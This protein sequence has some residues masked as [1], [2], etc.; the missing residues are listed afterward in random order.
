MPP[1]AIYSRANHKISI[2]AAV[3]HWERYAFRYLAG[4]VIVLL[5]GGTVFY[6]IVER[7]SWVNA[8]YFCVVTLTT[9]GYGDVVPKTDFGKIFTTFYIMIGV[10]VI[11]TFL[12]SLGDVA[13]TNVLPHYRTTY[14][15]V[16]ATSAP[17]PAGRTS[18]GAMKV[19]G[20][21]DRS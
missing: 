11:T 8:Y 4:T 2:G 13:G 12:G 20:Q 3:T 1:A 9:V 18:A 7:F 19:F 14:F 10:G 15:L 21:L 17:E 5:V 6:H 16:R